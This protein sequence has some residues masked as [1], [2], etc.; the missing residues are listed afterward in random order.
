LFKLHTDVQCFP[1]KDP[2]P[3]LNSNNNQ[4]TV[5]GEAI[6]F[7][8]EF[9]GNYHKDY[10]VYWQVTFQ[11]GSNITVDDDSNFFYFHIHTQQKC[12]STNYSCCHFITQLYI[13][14]TTMPLNNAMITCNAA[15]SSTTS[16]SNACYLS[17][18]SIDMV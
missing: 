11:N 8:C 2:I 7:Q 17:E 10:N 3:L 6:A 16:S 4:T 5:E 1:P 13:N 15:I 12:P 14:T 18:L 9:G